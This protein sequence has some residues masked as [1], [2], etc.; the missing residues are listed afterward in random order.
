M[1]YVSQC[2]ATN[3]LTKN[4]NTQFNKKGFEGKYRL[5]YAVLSHINGYNKETFRCISSND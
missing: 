3:Y 4:R 1:K 5:K 2:H